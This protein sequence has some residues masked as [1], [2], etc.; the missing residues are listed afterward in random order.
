MDVGFWTILLVI[1]K[2]VIYVTSF[3]AIGSLIYS[4]I[5]KFE[6]EYTISQNNKVLYF[7]S[8]IAILSSIF[9]L[10]V[11]TG[12]L[13]DDGL[14]GMLDYEVMQIFLEGNL[15]Y[16]FYIRISGL[17]LLILLT[18]FVPNIK[19]LYLIP[20]I[21]VAA[22]FSLV[23]HASGDYQYLTMLFLIIH[24]LAIAFWVGALLPLYRT[25]NS[26]NA[27]DLLQGFGKI[28]TFIVPMLLAVGL[29]FAYIIVGNFNALFTSSY[30]L[31]L[32]TKLIVVGLLLGLATINKLILVPQISINSSKSRLRLRQV[33]AVET[34]AFI[35]IFV[36]T[37]ILTTS[38]NLPE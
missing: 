30:G 7:A 4:R 9:F 6:P 29:A 31:T 21:L 15:G 14:S 32:I 36:I 35:L 12:F 26:S 37:A 28:A 10:F 19:L 11:Q 34:L 13:M 38:T 23:G 25:S 16:S 17:A 18:F 5:F 22:S 1:T 8:G 33:I 2:A 27:S 3:L 24:L 20:A